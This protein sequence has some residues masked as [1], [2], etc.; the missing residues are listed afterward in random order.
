MTEERQNIH[1]PTGH[2]PGFTVMELLVAM[3]MT[4]LVMAMV[5][6]HVFLIRERYLDDIVRTRINSNLR[7]GMDIVSMNIRQAGENLQTRFPV[8]ELTNGAGALPD[9]LTLRRNLVNEV[10]TICVA[11]G[12]GATTLMVSSAALGVPECVPGNVSPLRTVFENFRTAND[13]SVRAFVYNQLTGSGQF[14][15]F[16]G[17]G[18]S[19]GEHYIQTSGVSAAY[20]ARTSNVY[21]LEEYQFTRNTVENTLQLIMDGETSEPQAVSFS[22]TDFQVTIDM[23]DGTQVSALNFS[24]TQRWRDIRQVRVR[25]AGQE[26]RRDRQISSSIESAYFPRNVLSY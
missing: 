8:V 7:S 11:A 13:G 19:G 16:T 2:D 9:T 5:I 18:I 4:S 26:T 10:L 3:T 12:A 17:S 20:P 22:V 6:G 25:L 14:V 15:D 1:V 24:S 23:D 21:L